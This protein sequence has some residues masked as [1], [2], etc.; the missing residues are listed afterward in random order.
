MG[1]SVEEKEKILK[2]LEEDR[3]FRYAL[4]GLLGFKEILERITRIEEIIA[5]IE[6]RQQRLE[7]RQQKL[8]ERQQKLEERFAKLEERFA[9]LKKRQLMLEERFARLEER[10]QKLEER[11]ARIEER[12]LKLEERMARL[13]EEMNE[14]RRV[15][16]VIA[17]R[18]GVLSESAFR[19]AMKYVVE[20]KLGAGRVSKMSLRDEEGLVYGYP[21]II[22]IDV[23]VKDDKHILVE[24]KSRVSRGDVY[25]IYRIGKLYEKIK[26]VK[27]V[28]VI[29][30]GFIDPKAYEAA[31]KLGVEVKPVIRE[32]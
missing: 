11:M 16:T 21:S 14:T 13:E 7:E 32:S 26:G 17:H 30:G 4:M 10:Q 20:E 6:E 27:P 1:L 8:E 3:E 15:L 22:D 9:E 31:A 18:F 5:R 28:L 12:Q 25:E 24:V 29:V 2:A 23:V 19:E